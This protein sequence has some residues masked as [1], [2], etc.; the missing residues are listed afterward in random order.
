MCSTKVL[1]KDHK[2]TTMSTSSFGSNGS[3]DCI[4]WHLKV[5]ESGQSVDIIS[6]YRYRKGSYPP[7][8][9][10]APPEVVD[11]VSLDDV[12]HDSNVDTSVHY[13]MF[14]IESSSS[15]GELSL[16]SGHSW[17]MEIKQRKR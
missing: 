2:R 12:S 6:T 14:D 17:E 15:D 5:D 11:L 13:D 8:F 9:V 7:L 4:G 16:G 10:C 1:K 3:S